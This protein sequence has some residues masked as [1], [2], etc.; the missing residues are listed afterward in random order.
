MGTGRCHIS[1]PAEMA[2][3]G[4]QGQKEESQG[5]CP[6]CAGVHR[7]QPPRIMWSVGLFLFLFFHKKLIPKLE[8]LDL[9]HNGVLVVDN[10]QVINAFGDFR[11]LQP[12]SGVPESSE[13][14]A[15]LGVGPYPGV[16]SHSHLKGIWV[17]LRFIGTGAAAIPLGSQR[18]SER[19]LP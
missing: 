14:C 18:H 11:H 6:P 1:G 9:S 10:L 7:V 19:L 12:S 16:F 2:S 17:S 4:V 15:A 13:G 3:P 8:F 5:V